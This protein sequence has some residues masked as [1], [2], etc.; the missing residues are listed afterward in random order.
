M[1]ALRQHVVAFSAVA[2]SALPLS[3]IP[4]RTVSSSSTS[5]SSH[6]NS[7]SNSSDHGIAQVRLRAFDPVSLQSVAS[8]VVAAGVR[9][10][11]SMSGVIPRPKLT[12]LYTV[13]RSPHIDKKA[14][15]QFHMIVRS[16]HAVIW[17]S[18]PACPV[19]PQNM[20]FLTKWHRKRLVIVKSGT[21]QALGAFQAALE[22][23]QTAWCAAV[24]PWKRR[25]LLLVFRRVTAVQVD[26]K[27]VDLNIK[28]M[29]KQ[30]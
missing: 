21:P 5:S 11:L 6:V 15:D 10:G 7:S 30:V 23:V 3:G 9:A 26:K 12:R 19:A 27:G 28:H 13:L 14:R 1:N 24:S 2:R 17:H 20:P 8:A 4:V 25:H 18:R 22:Q 16:E 29:Q